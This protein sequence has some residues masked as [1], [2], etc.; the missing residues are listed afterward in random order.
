VYYKNDD[1]KVSEYGE[2]V[3]E[4]EEAKGNICW[5]TSQFLPINFSKSIK[6]AI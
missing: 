6:N 1:Y 4:D 2:N 5:R 3:L